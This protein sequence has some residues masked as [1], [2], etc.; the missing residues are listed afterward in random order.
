[1]IDLLQEKPLRR[2]RSD[3]IMRGN[4]LL[5]E[6]LSEEIIEDLC[7]LIEANHH[8]ASPLTVLRPDWW[9]LVK[10]RPL[11]WVVLCDGV[12]VGYCAHLVQTHVFFGEKQAVCAAVYLRPEHRARARGMIRQIERELTDEGV[13]SISYSVPHWS[14]AGAFFEAIGYECAE[15]IMVKKIHALPA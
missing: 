4:W 1:M 14:R 15:L 5:R 12:T 10:M 3:H 9:T 11:F 7:L 8:A 13:S 6:T 2:V